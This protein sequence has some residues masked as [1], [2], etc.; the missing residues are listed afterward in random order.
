MTNQNNAAQAANDN[1]LS[2]EYV[3]AVIQRHGYD[4]PESVIAQLH[5]WIGLHGGENT[6]TL[7]MYEAHKA[8]SKL[9]AP[10]AG[11][12]VSWQV[13]RT[14]GSPLAC[15]ETC[16]KELYDLTK[17]TGRY[18]GFENGPPCEVRALGVI[19]AAPQ[20]SPVAGEAQI[21]VSKLA[22][23]LADLAS[24]MAYEANQ[25]MDQ[26]KAS[27]AALIERGERALRRFA[28]AA[29]QASAEDVRNVHTAALD[30]DMAE[31]IRSP[32]NA[33]MHRNECRAMLDRQQRAGDAADAARYRLA[34]ADCI[35]IL[36]GDAALG[37]AEWDSKLDNLAK[38]KGET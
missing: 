36:R 11:E 21:E 25:E 22:E 17:S 1:P 16:T 23:E 14:D 33:C 27:Q 3:N 35:L 6:G 34:V 24:D 32:S 10:V 20:A 7:L 26:D 4:S 37:R 18:S 31:G 19:D 38:A 15:W 28:G 30:V 9:R 2:D 13:R 8:L 29:P 12:A 5:Q